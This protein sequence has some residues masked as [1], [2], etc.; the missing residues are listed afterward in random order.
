MKGQI[1][2]SSGFE[3]QYQNDAIRTVSLLVMTEEEEE[4]EDLGSV[5]TEIVPICYIIGFGG[6]VIFFYNRLVST[7][8]R[9]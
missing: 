6:H 7:Q 3:S 2:C 8:G 4:E 5:V 1:H 9:N